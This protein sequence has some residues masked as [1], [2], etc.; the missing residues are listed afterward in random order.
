MFK[1]KQRV[2]GKSGP[3]KDNSSL[4]VSELQWEANLTYAQYF[5]ECLQLL[6]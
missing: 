2:K 6:L 4:H 3:S 5:K 1:N